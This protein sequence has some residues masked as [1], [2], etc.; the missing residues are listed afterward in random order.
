MKMPPEW[1]RHDRTWMAWPGPGYLFGTSEADAD[2]AR[3][4]W[5]AVANATVDF[6]PVTILVP[7][8]E[9]AHAKRALSG[10]VEIVEAELNDA[11]MRDIGPTFAFDGDELVAINWVFNGWGAQ[12]WATWDKDARIG[13]RVAELAG[14]RVVDSPLVNEGGGIHVNGE[15]QVL[16]TRTVQLDQGRNP[17]WSPERVEAEFAEKLG[18]EQTIWLPRGLTR[19]SEEFGT[20]GHVDIVASYTPDGRVLV[21]EQ[22][23][24][25]HPDFEVSKEIIASLPRSF[26]AAGTPREILRVPA[27]K[28]LR[29][30]EGWVDYS[31]INHLVANDA[32]IACGFAD[33]ND[34]EAFEVLADA[35]PGREIVAIDARPIFARGGGI[36]CITQQQPALV[37]EAAR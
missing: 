14:V 23:D 8:S 17:G 12:E 27:P 36:H 31:Y 33:P 25:A 34:A 9:L 37:T 19:D 13:R 20:R 24:P 30:A 28:E 18:A 11:W 32:V 16:A 21:H 3:A 7:T 1:T 10:R 15:G 2:E 26:E 22:R 4:T 6:E 29:D 35:Y 5:A